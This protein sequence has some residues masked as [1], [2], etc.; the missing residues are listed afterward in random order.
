MK[1]EINLVNVNIF[2]IYYY[3]FNTFG[4]NKSVKKWFSSKC[5][6]NKNK[7]IMGYFYLKKRQTRKSENSPMT[8]YWNHLLNYLLDYVPD[9]LQIVV[10]AEMLQVAMGVTLLRQLHCLSHTL[11]WWH[12]LHADELS[13]SA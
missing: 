6:G 3:L 7:Q 4:K 11:D 9:Y 13:R 12:T 8:A 5:I 2:L 1:S 10:V